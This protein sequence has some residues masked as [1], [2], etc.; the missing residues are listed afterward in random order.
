[1]IYH[2]TKTMTWNKNRRNAHVSVWTHPK[3]SPQSPGGLKNKKPPFSRKGPSIKLWTDS[4]CN[5]RVDVLYAFRLT[6][7]CTIKTQLFDISVN[8]LEITLSVDGR[9]HVVGVLRSVCCAGWGAVPRRSRFTHSCENVSGLAGEAIMLCLEPL[10][11]R[12]MQ[13]AS[14]TFSFTSSYLSIPTVCKPL[15]RFDHLVSV[16]SWS[17]WGSATLLMFLCRIE[18]VVS[19]FAF[20]NWHCRVV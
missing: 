15:L 5:I 18:F 20:P 10:C 17:F 1:M 9:W 14:F 3:R 12:M 19:C 11:V 13:L 4:Y 16:R 8:G 6:S 7:E 2:E